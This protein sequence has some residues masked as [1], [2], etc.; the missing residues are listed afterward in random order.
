MKPLHEL[1]PEGRRF[2]AEYGGGLSSHLPMLLVA[3]ERLGVDDPRLSDVAT[4][5]RERLDAAPRALS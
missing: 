1:L 4:H 5:D 3:L 2:D